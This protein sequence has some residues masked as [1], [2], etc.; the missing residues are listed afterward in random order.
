MNHREVG[1]ALTRKGFSQ[2][3]GGSHE[4]YCFFDENGAKTEIFTVLSRKRRNTVL[5]KQL[6][7]MMAKQLKITNRQFRDFVECTLDRAAYEEILR[8]KQILP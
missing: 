4:K 2:F 1:K 6:A 5:T 8:R 3:H 7:G